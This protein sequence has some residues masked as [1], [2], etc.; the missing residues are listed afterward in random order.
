MTAFDPKE[1][2]AALPQAAGRVSHVGAR[3]RAA[4]RR[5]GA[6]PEEPRRQLFQPRAKV[7]PQDPGAG[8][9]RSP[10]IEVTVT[11]SETEALLLE[12]NLIKAHRPR[13]NVMLRDDK[14]FPYI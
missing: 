8:R 13:F 10:R 4:V 14:S 5:Q 9:R 12:Y 2:V 3:R 11:S 1:F 6:Q 7:D